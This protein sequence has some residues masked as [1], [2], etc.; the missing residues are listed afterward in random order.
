M[1][2]LPQLT[3]AQFE[4]VVEQLS[5]LL[6]LDPN[7]IEFDDIRA[8]LV[9]TL[10]K[11]ESLAGYLEADTIVF[12]IDAIAAI[13]VYTQY[14]IDAAWA[15][16][17]LHTALG[18]ASIRAIIRTLGVRQRRKIPAQMTALFTHSGVANENDPLNPQTIPAYS[19]FVVGGNNFFNREPIRFIKRRDFVFHADNT[20]PW[21]IWGSGK[22]ASDTIWVSDYN[23]NKLFAYNAVTGEYDSSKDIDLHTDNADARGI[24][25]DGTTMWVVN[26]GAITSARKLFAYTISNG[27]QNTSEEFDLVTNDNPRGIARRDAPED[28][29][30]A[31]STWWISDAD[32][33]AYAYSTADTNPQQPDKNINLQ[34][35]SPATTGLWADTE[36]D[37]LYS[38]SHTRCSH[39][40]D[41]SGEDLLDENDINIPNR[42]FNLADQNSSPRGIWSNG[43]TLWVVDAGRAYSYHL[44]T[45]VRGEQEPSEKTATLYQGTIK[46]VEYTVGAE[47]QDYA[48][49][50]SE[51]SNFQVADEDVRVSFGTEPNIELLEVVH[52]P[53]WRY[54][55]RNTVGGAHQIHN[56]SAG[57]YVV[58]WLSG[59]KIRYTELWETFD[60][61]Y[62]V[63]YQIC[64]D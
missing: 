30:E 26:A 55:N 24:W 46:E 51:E 33:I 11:R 7:T 54:R 1:A 4:D 31:T 57:F 27:T 47:A 60:C 6:R 20:H 39:V 35:I 42:E 48:R 2:H 37:R 40:F 64:T 56:V 9:S 23:A 63:E 12:L 10:A 36:N 16:G 28:D 19:T 49:F 52:D 45:G 21:G 22:T 29:D 5:T 38:V 44:D 62:K 13:G 61:R 43:T 8:A 53:L 17:N 18:N 25:S 41:I 3:D 32:G 58:R 50:V 15:E 59:I 34:I 14:S